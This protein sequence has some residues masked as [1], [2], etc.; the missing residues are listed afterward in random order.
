MIKKAIKTFFKSEISIGI[1]LICVTLLSLF[2]VNSDNHKIYEDFF[3]MDLP[4]NL[5]AIHI[6][7]SMNLREWINDALM[8]IFFLLV[9][10]ELKRE[11]LVGE[12]STKKKFALPA[13]AAIGGVVFPALIFAYFNISDKDALS[14]FAVPTATDI[15]FAYGMICLFGKKVPNALKVFLVALAVLDDLM[16]ILI[17]AFFYTQNFSPIYLLF[18]TFVLIGLMFL[19]L[20]NSKRISLYLV[21]GAILWL[22]ILKSGIHATLAGVLTAAFIP[23]NVKNENTLSNL[24]HKIAPSVNFFI[25]PIFAFANA[26]VRIAKMELSLF[27]DSLVIGTICGLFFGKQFGVMA[28]SYIAVKLKIVHLPRGSNWVEF[29]GASILTGIGFTMSL[30][31]GSLA[32]SGSADLYDKIKIGVL[33]GS[34]LS[35]IFGI[36]I[37]YLG[38]LKINWFYDSHAVK[39]ES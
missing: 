14:G 2:F 39:D 9:G 33:A 23:L 3:L 6:Y 34:L 18:A 19:N 1:T 26:G 37:V 25:L 29:Y 20:K 27:T 21:L 22:M 36:F 28:M 24:A 10:L 31:I 4:L 7:K 16:A 13:I 17:I 35:M 32:F 15:A 30:F 8:A 12:L 11:V 38:T 5:S